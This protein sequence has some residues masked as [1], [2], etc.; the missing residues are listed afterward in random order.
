MRRITIKFNKTDARHW[1]RKVVFQTRASH[2]YSVQIQFKGTRHWLGLGTAN[3]EEAAV[4]ARNLYL[5]IRAHG[6][7]AVMARRRGEAHEKKVNVTIGEYLEAVAAHSLA[8]D[9]G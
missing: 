7:D 6:W 9:S 3:K 1:E 8:E 5:E 4:L 2:T